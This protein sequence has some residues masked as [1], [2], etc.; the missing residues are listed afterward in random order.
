MIISTQHNRMLSDAWYKDSMLVGRDKLFRYL[1]EKYPD[2]HPT[3]MQV[4]EWLKMQRV[5]QIHVRAP[6]R[7]PTKS[8]IVKN[9][10]RYMQLDLTGPFTRDR[11]FTWIMGLIDVRRVTIGPLNM[12][13]K[14][15]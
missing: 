6:P 8:V 5:H 14:K 11:G 10:S 12:V 1:T 3:R 4:M 15:Q 2:N 9:K 7:M 13:Q